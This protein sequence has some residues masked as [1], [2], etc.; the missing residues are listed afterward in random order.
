VRTPIIIDGEPMAAARPAPRFG[1]H[2]DDILREI[3]EA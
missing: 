2:T 3:G 1:E